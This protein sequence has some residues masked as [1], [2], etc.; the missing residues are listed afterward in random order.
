MEPIYLHSKIG[1]KLQLKIGIQEGK[2]LAVKEFLSASTCQSALR[3]KLTFIMENSI[4]IPFF[5][6][7]NSGLFINCLKHILALICSTF[8]QNLFT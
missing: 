5:S 3:L 2:K 1:G 8:Q 7:Y 6:G 4:F